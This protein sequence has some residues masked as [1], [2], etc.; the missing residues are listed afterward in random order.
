[1]KNPFIFEHEL[2]IAA[3]LKDEAPYVKDWIEYHLLIGVTKFYLYDNGSRDC[4]KDVLRPYREAGIVEYREFPGHC[5]QLAA[6]NDAILRHRFDC[7]YMAFID[8]D[9]Y[10]RPMGQQMLP[11]VVAEVLAA[12]EDAAGVTANWRV[13]GSS[14]YETKDL[15]IP[16]WQR[17]VYRAEDDFFKCEAVKSIVDPRAV[18][19]FY[20]HNAR[21][22]AGRYAVDENGEKVLGAGNK[23]H[24]FHQICIHHYF[25]RSKEEYAE[26]L[27]RGNA[28]SRKERGWEDF[29]IFDRNEVRDDGI[30]DSISARRS[31]RRDLWEYRRM[32]QEKLIASIQ[33][34][35]QV[36]E[37]SE[38][39]WAGQTE[40]LLCCLHGCRKYSRY[41]DQQSVEQIR[42]LLL[43]K[44]SMALE[45]KMYCDEVQLLFSALPDLMKP[46]LSDVQRKIMRRAM[47]WGEIGSQ[48]CLETLQW[49]AYQ[50][51]RVTMRA[52]RPLYHEILASTS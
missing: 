36:M 46:P 39:T 30:C 21:Y 47:E 15:A 24:P 49:E 20:I 1:M 31:H 32:S 25:T 37:Q 42:E 27:E 43:E 19:F 51:F 5:K 48:Y 45:Q 23:R 28:T 40:Y 34:L 9:E 52:L 26:K 7:R 11:E 38:S 44:L 16:V 10:L 17:Y 29:E 18:E 2:A 6:Y 4:L 50:Y 22:F 41:L 13:F 8:V 12:H 35:Q 3:I 33:M 14:G